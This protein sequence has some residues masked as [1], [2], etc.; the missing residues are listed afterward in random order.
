M[1]LASR[2]FAAALCLGLAGQTMAATELK[3]WPAPA[4][5]QL[6]KMIAANGSGNMAFLSSHPSGPDRIRQLQAT[7][8]KVENLY[9]QAGG[10]G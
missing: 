3:H 1:K 2:L 4:A 7:I 9:R 6:N 5:E 10:K 8:P